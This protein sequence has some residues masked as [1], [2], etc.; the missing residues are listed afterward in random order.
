MFAGA[1]LSMQLLST[2]GVLFLVVFAIIKYWELPGFWNWYWKD[3]KTWGLLGMAA[4][5]WLIAT[6]I[7]YGSTFIFIGL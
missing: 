6:L 7:K 5:L 2:I 3:Y 4:F 1:I